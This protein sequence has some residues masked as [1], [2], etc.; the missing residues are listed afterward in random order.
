[1]E[2]FY[3]PVLF[4]IGLKGLLNFFFLG[5]FFHLSAAFISLLLEESSH[6]RTERR[7][8]DGSSVLTVFWF[9]SD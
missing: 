2:L 8:K 9:F 7:R 4:Q 6:S 1:M 3:C 5:S